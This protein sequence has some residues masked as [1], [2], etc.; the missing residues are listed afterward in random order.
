MQ[1]CVGCEGFVPEGA[2]ACPN[3]DAAV[4]QDAV[5]S[6]LGRVAKVVA[7]GAAAMTLMAC[8]GGPVAGYRPPAQEPQTAQP[9]GPCPNAAAAAVDGN[10]DG[11]TRAACAPVPSAGFAT[12]PAA[13]DAPPPAPPH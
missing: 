1:T 2:R 7:C 6:T 10:Q 11:E 13:S 12:P 5:R 8:Y 9:S 3:C 4:H